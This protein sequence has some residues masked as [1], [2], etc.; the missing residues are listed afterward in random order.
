MKHTQ[1]HSEQISV[2]S[3]FWCRFGDA[4][5]MFGISSMYCL[6]TDQFIHYTFS[7]NLRS[8]DF[9]QSR[10]SLSLLLVVLKFIKEA[11]H[12][13]F[14][15]NNRF[16][17]YVF[18]LAPILDNSNIECFNMKMIRSFLNQKAHQEV[19]KYFDPQTV[20]LEDKFA[21]STFRF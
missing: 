9:T 16:F 8:S 13:N 17:T 21:L 2:K 4:K 11:I 10:N 18:N 19:S 1:T 20:I 14:L 7:T 15:S 12:I 3:K 6:F 5:L